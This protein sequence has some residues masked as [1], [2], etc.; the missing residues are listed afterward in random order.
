AVGKDDQGTGRSASCVSRDTAGSWAGHVRGTNTSVVTRTHCN[1]T[2]KCARQDKSPWDSG[3]NSRNLQPRRFTRLA[4]KR[5]ELKSP[6][7]W[8][9]KCWVLATSYSRTAYRRTTIGAAAFHF[10]VRNGNGW[11]HRARVTRVRNRT[12]ISL[13]RSEQ[14]RGRISR[15][16]SGD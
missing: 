8:L 12:G 14:A 15:D 7:L 10:R 4:W 11:G 13:L 5:Y 1:N 16:N 6:A 9:A 2:C 3:L